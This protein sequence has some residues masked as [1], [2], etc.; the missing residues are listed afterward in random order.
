MSLRI[1]KFLLWFIRVGVV[2]I[3]FL[4]LLVY[5]P[6]FYP[7]IFSK[8]VAFQAIVEIIFVAWLFLAIY[9][10]KKYRPDW[11]NPLV[12]ALTLF[13]AALILTALTGVD[14]FRSF[15]ST[16]QRMNG[17]L[18]IVHF[19]IC[20][21]ILISGFRTW[22]DWRELV[23]ASLLS[24]F[25][26]CLYGVGQK[27]E[28]W[29]LLPG[30]KMAR[31][32]WAIRPSGPLG[33][34]IFFAVYTALH[35]FLAIFLCL[36]ENKLVRKILVIIFAFFN[37]AM[38]L[39]AASRGVILALGVAIFFFLCFLAFYNFKQTKTRFVKMGK[40][41]ARLT[42]I[43]LIIIA[44]VIVA[45]LP[46]QK[47]KDWVKGAPDFVYRLVD[48]TGG[49]KDRITAWQAGWKGFKDRPIF[50]QGWENYNVIFNQNYQPFYFRGGE[51]NTW[52][53]R[54]HNQIVDLMALTGIVGTLSYLAVWIAVFWLLLYKRATAD[55]SNAQLP[56]SE[57][58]QIIAV[59]KWA[60]ATRVLISCLFLFYFIQ[61]LFVFDNPASLIVF[62]FCLGLVYFITQSDSNTRMRQNDPNKEKFKTSRKIPLPILIFLIAVF[63]PWAI[64]KF[65]IE[66]FQQSRLGVRALHTSEVDLRSGLYWYEKA[67]AKPAFTNQEIRVYLAQTIAEEYQK[68]ANETDFNL[69]RQGTEM[70]IAEYQKSVQEHPL[71]A[72]Q[73]LYLG[74]LYN[75]AV[76][77]NRDYIKEAQQALEKALE[78]S[79]RRQQIYFELAKTYLYQEDYVR[80]IDILQKAVM[81]DD[82]VEK[83]R[84][85][86]KNVL[87][88]IEKENPEVVKEAKQFLQELENNDL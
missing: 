16:Q 81:L 69:L 75:L 33:N 50:G 62:Y 8:M 71:D 87:E 65:N 72:R 54:S 88:V 6:V 23:W 83:S 1:E 82:Q 80:A 67:L 52:F 4:P 14:I 63:L 19:Y 31:G 76:H 41:G 74:Q 79:P 68:I 60:P 30:E 77:Y 39:I 58:A 51:E 26:V 44:V 27:M 25:L 48:L 37:L 13:T 46:T 43:L 57:I 3:L 17:I 61:N 18:V 38:A 10:G 84:Q 55:C 56:K 36:K 40:I 64:Y 29:F 21:L 59:D 28:L 85:N 42:L 53:D 15:W 32:Y 11:R 47:D 20:F 66:P 73:W 12:A 35:F 24:S 22:K 45:F 34:S 78:L 49:I 70:A 2:I 5:K 9:G 86:L 7:Y